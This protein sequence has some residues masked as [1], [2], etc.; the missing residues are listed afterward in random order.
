MFSS[1]QTIALRWEFFFN[2]VWQQ[3]WSEL[4]AESGKVAE[5]VFAGGNN[6]NNIVI[7][8]IVIL[9]QEF[10]SVLNAELLKTDTDQAIV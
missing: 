4:P 10:I 7:M 9:Q 5:A 8:I 1:F 2:S 3:V 6:D